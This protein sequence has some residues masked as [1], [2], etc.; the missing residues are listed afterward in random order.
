ML[1]VRPRREA[2]PPPPVREL[3]GLEA[4][5]QGTTEGRGLSLWVEASQG[6]QNCLA[7]RWRKRNQSGAVLPSE[8]KVGEMVTIPPRDEEGR[9]E[10]SEGESVRWKALGGGQVPTVCL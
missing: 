7:L 10:G 5:Y 9:E 3:C 2:D 4:P 8:T 6:A 1:V